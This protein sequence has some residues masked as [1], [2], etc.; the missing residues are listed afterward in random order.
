MI[1][2]PQTQNQERLPVPQQLKNIRTYLFQLSS[3]LQIN[4]SDMEAEIKNLREE[5][6]ALKEKISRYERKQ[7]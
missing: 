1:N 4:L 2:I 7:S 3:E 5:N 6:E